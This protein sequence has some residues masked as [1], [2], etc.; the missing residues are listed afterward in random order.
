[1][2]KDNGKLESLKDGLLVGWVYTSEAAHHYIKIAGITVDIENLILRKDV[3]N[4]GYGDGLCGFE[5]NLKSLLKSNE[6]SGLVDVSLYA[7][8][9]LLS[10]NQ[11]KIPSSKDINLN[12][13][14][15][16][17]NN[18]QM[19][20]HNVRSPNRFSWHLD[21]YPFPNHY[22]SAT[23]YT[24]IWINSKH[25]SDMSLTLTIK[26]DKKVI[27][28]SSEV[29]EFLEFALLAR[30]SN[31]S[32]AILKV[33]NA[34]KDTIIQEPIHFLPGWEVTKIL[35]DQAVFNDAILN[36]YE[37]KIIIPNDSTIFYD[38]AMIKLAE[39]PELFDTAPENNYGDE[40][41][42]GKN[43]LL[44]GDLVDW[45]NGFNFNKLKRGSEI[46]DFWYFEASKQ[47]IGNIR[48]F[49][50][51]VKAVDTGL[52]LQNPNVGLRAITTDLEG[53]AR[54]LVKL[55]AIEIKSSNY[56]LRLNVC[57]LGPNK[58]LLIPRISVM[59]RNHTK[60]HY[61]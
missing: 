57:A 19:V 25:K 34:S 4:A 8:D 28:Q 3:L 9:T 54:I 12:C 43:L 59:G 11:F 47:N 60:D 15:N 20:A 18:H 49:A 21:T 6:I 42:V 2:R 32:E 38:F 33:E 13:C 26:L 23:K 16:I 1:M 29:C 52:E 46:A 39:E 48:F 41:H 58:K 10:S 17:E 61:I 14:F 40:A 51:P 5:L 36:K 24:R 22:S 31:Y 37:L 35:L 30:A 7:G 56:Q 50:Q 55:S 44:N 45:N 53:Y 27:K